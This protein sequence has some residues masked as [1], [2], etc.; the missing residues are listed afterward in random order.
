MN[1]HIVCPRDCRFTRFLVWASRWAWLSAGM[2]IEA[3]RVGDDTTT[4]VRI[5]AP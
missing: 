2:R 5:S 4:W 3:V 1:A